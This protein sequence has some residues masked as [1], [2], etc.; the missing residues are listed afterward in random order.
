MES[1]KF[2]EQDEEIRTKEHEEA[3]KEAMK[4]AIFYDDWDQAGSDKWKNTL[5]IGED[6][7]AKISRA[8]LESASI[9]GHKRWD[10]ELP[11][12]KVDS[13][14]ALE[15]LEKAEKRHNESMKNLEKQIE[16]VKR[17]L[18]LIEHAKVNLEKNES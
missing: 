10:F 5:L 6:G 9:W 7:I 17:Q 13:K 1:E 15:C 3:Q 11:A 8:R 12:D 2:S 18:S 4:N 16:E 14:Y